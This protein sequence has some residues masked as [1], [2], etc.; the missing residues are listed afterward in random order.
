MSSSRLWFSPFWGTQRRKSV[1]FSSPAT[2]AAYRLRNNSCNL[3]PSNFDEKE[4][5]NRLRE[6]GLDEETLKRKDKAALVSHIAKLE[7]ELYDYQYN[8]GIVLLERKD[9][10]SECERIKASA[11]E[12]EEKL[13]E[14]QASHAAT[15]AEAVKQEESLKKALGIEKQCVV[16][17]E[18]AL[19]EMRAASAEAKYTSEDLYSKAREMIAT[20]DEKDLAAESKIR[21]GEALIGEANRKKAD[22]ERKLF[23]LEGREDA[24]R[25][26]QQAFKSECEARENEFV[27]QKRNLHDWEK[28][29]SDGQEKLSEGQTLLNQKEEFIMKKLDALKQTEGELE[30]SKQTIEK[31][32]SDM[33]KKEIELRANLASLAIREEALIERE[34][35]IDKKEKDLLLLQERLATREREEI[36]RLTRIHEASLEES[37]IEFE[38]ELEQKRRLVEDE[39][40][41]KK[42]GADLREAEVKYR[43]DKLSK[44]ECQVEKMVERLKEKEKNLDARSR[45]LR[46]R[47]RSLKKE[48]KELQ[49]RKEQ[50]EA[51]I[52]K[53]NDLNNELQSL[54]ASIEEQKC[55]IIEEQKKLEAAYSEREESIT[56]Q[57]KLKEEI[58]ILRAREQDLLKQ[59]DALFQEKQD[60][61]K[62]WEILD[63]K[64]EH[65][66]EE[67]ENVASERR[68]LTK[69]LKNEEER[70]KQEKA[71]LLEAIKQERVCL[72]LEKEA[73]DKSIQ[74]ER[75]ELFSSVERERED[76]I[77]ELELT[78]SEMEFTLEKRKEEMEK[79]YR[80][81][82][83][84]F[85]KM[86]EKELE[87]LNS[88]KEMLQREIEEI[89]LE[90]NSLE[91]EREELAT[92]RETTE[93]GW[94]DMKKDIEELQIQREKLKELRESL[95]KEREEY[96]A[97]LVELKKLKPEGALTEESLDFSEQQPLM[98]CGTGHGVYAQGD[99]NNKVASE[100]TPN[101]D[102]D[103]V[104][105]NTLMNFPIGN[106]SER[107]PKS[108]SRTLPP[109]KWLQRCASGLFKNSSD[110]VQYNNPREENKSTTG[111]V[112]VEL[113]RTH[114]TDQVQL[115]SLQKCKSVRDSN[116]S[117][118]RQFRRTH[119]IKDVVEQAEELLEV[120]LE[121]DNNESAEVKESRGDSHGVL[122]DNRDESCDNVTKPI[123]SGRKRR[124]YDRQ[125]Q[126]GRK[127]QDTFIFEVESENDVSAHRNKRQRQGRRKSIY[128]NEILKGSRYN[129]RD[130]TINT[131]SPTTDSLEL[132]CHTSSNIASPKEESQHIGKE[133]LKGLVQTEAHEEILHKSYHVQEKNLT[134]EEQVEGDSS[135]QISQVFNFCFNVIEQHPAFPWILPFKSEQLAM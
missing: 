89:R 48:E 103:T 119:S 31:E 64:K 45:H 3:S 114:G 25:R 108:A 130:S 81:K 93:R 97:Q 104:A 67:F 61:E 117:N 111:L 134:G 124:F 113:D 5:W 91:K 23:E 102:M 99:P 96:Q 7:S 24:L 87:Q 70:L 39:L 100:M 72:Q 75:T 77:R 74:H 14:E 71:L 10:E 88:Q 42:I 86:K 32:H 18:K 21:A 62:E 35:V 47:E 127:G 90:R 53:I 133:G 80:E 82:R 22:V 69:W 125:S 15:R 132:Q 118:R 92:N 60:F 110:K 34:I 11:T 115:T 16:D 121:T 36:Q 59:A 122:A 76:L 54:K 44:R 1:G 2:D 112:L 28:R 73:F 78:K 105:G 120:S 38:A 128:E 65:L 9:I 6:I 37:K 135:E 58:D 50:L 123:Y 106:S 116:R 46:E 12:Y 79:E 109:L 129:F 29:I 13:R 4:L 56:L 101:K 26:E 68:Q 52:N 27:L 98:I 41:S 95:H 107:S 94:S 43:E 55:Q 17:L 49:S 8:M 30:H 85:R 33:Q 20:A 57:T 40:E 51:Q 131:A 126:S 19:H 84:S 66:R 83:F 63:E